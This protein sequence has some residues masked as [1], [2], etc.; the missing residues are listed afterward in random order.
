MQKTFNFDSF[1][2]SLKELDSKE[3]LLDDDFEFTKLE[4]AEFLK[5]NLGR[6]GDPLEDIINSIDYA[7]SKD[8]GKG[9]FVLVL[10]NAER[11]TGSVVVNDTGMEGYIPEHV[12]VY[13]A[14]DKD[15]RGKGIGSNLLKET[16]SRCNGDISLHVEYDNPARKLYEKLGFKSK[17]AEMRYKS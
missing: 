11:I 16:I 8:K 10:Y 12:L 15:C 13:I 17:Y 2:L 6:Y 9:G 5:E 7:F 1:N 4:I 14:V 3:D